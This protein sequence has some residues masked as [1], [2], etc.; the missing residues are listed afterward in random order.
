MK[1][2]LIGFTALLVFHLSSTAQNVGET[3]Y[4][5]VAGSQNAFYVDLP[6][7]TSSF[8]EKEWKDYIG[9]YGKAKKVKKSSEWLVADTQILNIGGT[10][11]INLYSRSE[12]TGTA[13]RQYLWVESGGEYISSANNAD[14][15]KAAGDLLRDF[16]H[17]VKVDLIAIEL[18]NQQKALDN[19]EKD[20]SKL[21]KDNDGY[22]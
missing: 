1:K 9:Q 6:D 10:N 16:A 14:A 17:R 2:I 19:L 11:T 12:E 18:D 7:A 4:P 3:S 22:H 20:L 8:V 5:M 15:A 21:K 13:A